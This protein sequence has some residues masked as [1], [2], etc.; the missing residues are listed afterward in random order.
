MTDTPTTNPPRQIGVGL[1]SVGWMGKLHSR[2]YRNLPLVYPELGI[3]PRLVHA[4]DT[5][6]DRAAYAHDVLGYEKFTTDYHDVL[7]DPEVDVVSICAPNFLHAEM[8]IAAAKAGK[9]FWIEKPVGRNVDE[10]RSVAEAADAAGVVTSVG[11]NYRHAPVVEHIRQLVADGTLGRITNVRGR[12]FADYSAEPNGALSW[13]FIRSLAGSGVLGDLMGHLIDLVHYTVGPVAE[14]S[15]VTKTVYT[16]RPE[17]PMGSATHFAVIEGGVMKPVENEDYAGMLIRLAG[18]AAGADAVGTLEASRV[19]VGPRASYGLEIYG[20]EGS[21]RWDFQRMNEL[22]VA[23]GRSAAEFGY[24]TVYAGDGY[25]DFGHFQP[26]AGT[27][28]GYDDLKVIEA[29]K[30]LEAVTGAGQANS[31]IHDAVAANSVVTAAEQS[32]A[33]GRWQQIPDEAGS[34]TVA[35]RA[36][37]PEQVRHG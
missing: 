8:G 22:E 11:F 15:A 19:A 31:N 3:S 14:V 23:L 25:G 33:D 34:T 12:M 20:T 35:V 10:T 26:G 9:P 17:L 32:A 30:F 2:A 6:A 4:A 36:N 13:R 21:V 18:D 27:A 37:A 1:I 24:T 29:R 5:A 28:M 7:N 16:E